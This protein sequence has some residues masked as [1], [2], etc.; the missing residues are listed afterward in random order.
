MKKNIRYGLLGLLAVAVVA[1]TGGSFYMLGYSLT[2]K[3]NKGKDIPGSY[4]YMHSKYPFITPW[5]DSLQTTGVI[6]TMPSA[7]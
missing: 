5:L 6:R 3:D 4:E 2:P 7:C 1:L